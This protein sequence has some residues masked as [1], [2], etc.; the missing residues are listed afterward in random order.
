MKE[1]K[2]VGKDA[3]IHFRSERMRGLW[4]IQR[5]VST[6]NELVGLFSLDSVVYIPSTPPLKGLLGSFYFQA[7]CYSGDVCCPH[8]VT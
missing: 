5:E 1:D 3:E 4:G 7:L 2:Y 6:D 8:I